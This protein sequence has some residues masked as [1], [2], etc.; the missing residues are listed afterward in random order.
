MTPTE[1]H[2]LLQI[3][4]AQVYFDSYGTLKEAHAYAPFAQL[5]GL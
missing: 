4:F 3:I 2:G 5:L 1:Q